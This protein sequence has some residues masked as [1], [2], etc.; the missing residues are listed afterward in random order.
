MFELLFICL[1]L[2]GTYSLLFMFAFV[3]EKRSYIFLYSIN[4]E[5]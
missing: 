5:S 1:S 4:A 3:L 2:K